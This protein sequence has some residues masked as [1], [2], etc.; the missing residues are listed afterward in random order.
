M[1]LAETFLLSTGNSIPQLTRKPEAAGFT[2]VEFRCFDATRS[3]QSY[4][5]QS[6]HG[7]STVYTRGVYAARAPWIMGHLSFCATLGDG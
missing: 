4:I 6:A 3:Y 7:L 5:P 1:A 2:S